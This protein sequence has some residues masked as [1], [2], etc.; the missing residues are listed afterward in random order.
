[1]IKSNGLEYFILSFFSSIVV[2]DYE[3]IFSNLNQCNS[4]N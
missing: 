1:M 4:F 2:Y 3:N